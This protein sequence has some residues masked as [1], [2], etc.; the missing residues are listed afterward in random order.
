MSCMAAPLGTVMPNCCSMAFKLCAVKGAEVVLQ[1]EGDEQLKEVTDEKGRG[2][3]SGLKEGAYKG[4]L[5]HAGFEAQDLEV[6][7]RKGV[8]SFKLWVVKRG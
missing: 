5:S 8:V 2:L 6:V 4:R 7:I 1:R 3:F